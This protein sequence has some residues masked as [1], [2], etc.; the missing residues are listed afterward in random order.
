MSGS[1]AYGGPDA[2]GITK[3]RSRCLRSGPEL[4]KQPNDFRQLIVG[5]QAARVWQHPHSG[6]VNAFILLA[7]YGLRFGE[8]ATVSADTQNRHGARTITLHL[9]SQ[10]APAFDEIFFRQLGRG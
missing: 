8:R 3:P 4:S 1:L 2:G 7:N 10:R 9:R 5:I 6:G